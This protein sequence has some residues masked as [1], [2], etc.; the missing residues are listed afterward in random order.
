MLKSFIELLLCLSIVLFFLV[1]S[2]LFLFICRIMLLEFCY[3][4][5]Y[6]IHCGIYNVCKQLTTNK[7]T[8]SPCLIN[9]SLT[10]K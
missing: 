3:Y 9:P 7:Q 6:P 4:F 1:V 10:L 8:K 5:I 2:Y